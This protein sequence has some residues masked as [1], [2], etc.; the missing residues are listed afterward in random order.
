MQHHQAVT[1]LSAIA[2]EGRLA[3]FRYLVQASA[4]VAA[5]DL[6]TALVMP[7]STL[8]F[9]LKTLHHSGLVQVRQ[10]GR[11]MYYSPNRDAFNHLLGYLTE[12]CCGGSGCPSF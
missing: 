11:F 10:E 4:E 5:G 7:S 6:A 9:H 8:S 3:I 2:H 12:N 1:A